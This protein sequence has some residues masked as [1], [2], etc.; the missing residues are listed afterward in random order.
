MKKYSVEIIVI[1]IAIAVGAYFWVQ[2]NNKPEEPTPTFLDPSQMQQAE[3]LTVRL[4][5]ATV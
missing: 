2:E 5:A 1:V 3:Q 4:I